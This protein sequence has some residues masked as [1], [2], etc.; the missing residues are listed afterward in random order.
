MALAPEFE[1]DLILMEDAPV[2]LKEKIE[3]EGIEI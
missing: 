3:S 1:I 2:S